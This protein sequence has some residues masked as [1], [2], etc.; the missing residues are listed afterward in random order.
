MLS[1]AIDAHGATSERREISGFTYSV[2]PIKTGFIVY[3]YAIRYFD[4]ETTDILTAAGCG[5]DVVENTSATEADL[6]ESFCPELVDIIVALTDT[7]E[8]IAAHG[9]V[10]L[11]DIKILDMSDWGII[12]RI[13]DWIANAGDNPSEKFLDRVHHHCQFLLGHR[14]LLPIHKEMI[15]DLLKLIDRVRQQKTPEMVLAG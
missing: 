11:T 6:R 15:D 14:E 7:E 2:H 13:G 4:Q 9:K 10:S 5:H 12:V 3:S 8:E 1:L